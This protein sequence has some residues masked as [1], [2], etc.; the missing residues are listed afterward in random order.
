M[1][2]GCNFKNDKLA[3]PGVVRGLSCDES[4]D[5]IKSD[6]VTYCS[7]KFPFLVTLSWDDDD[8]T[9]YNYQ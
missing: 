9:L 5:V 8:T 3:G 6:R 1:N 7:T 4:S 2:G